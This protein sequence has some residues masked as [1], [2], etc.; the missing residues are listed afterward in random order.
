[1]KNALYLLDASIDF[2]KSAPDFLAL[3]LPINAD[4]LL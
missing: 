3:H 1:M 2:K 4:D